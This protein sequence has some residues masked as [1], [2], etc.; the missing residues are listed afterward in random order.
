MHSNLCRAY[1]GPDGPIIYA[2]DENLPTRQLHGA[3][4][5]QEH[6]P[7]KMENGFNGILGGDLALAGLN[8]KSLLKVKF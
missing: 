3:I 4:A 2:Y 8:K 7:L 6:T 5:V 1:R